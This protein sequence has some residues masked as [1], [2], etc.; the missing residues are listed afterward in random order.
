M[1]VPRILQHRDLNL[2]QRT[3][4]F[5]ATITGLT[6]FNIQFFKN[7]LIPPYDIDQVKK[8]MIELGIK[9][10]PI[11]SVTGFIIGLVL[12]MQSEPVLEKFGATDFL[13]ATVSLSVIR[14]LGPVITALIFAGRVSSGIG[15]ELGS[16]RVTEQIDAMEVS[17]IDPFNYLVVTR[18][19]A[20]TMILPILTIYVIFI[21]LGGSYLSIILNNTMSFE[22][23]KNSVLASLEFGD[24]IPSIAKTFVFGYIVGVVGCYKGYTTEGGTEGVGRASTTAV[25]LASLLILIFDMILVKLTLWLWPTLG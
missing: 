6:I 22:Y 8:H 23:F 1:K 3:Y 2:V 14:E 12:T 25:V 21:A 18:I 4:N 15:A 17:A 24:F 11:V 16:M 10:F 7:L 19:I 13:P 9:T 5:F 20:T